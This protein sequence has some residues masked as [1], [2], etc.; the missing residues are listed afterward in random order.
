MP[1]FEVSFHFHKVIKLR[2]EAPSEE[3]IYAVTDAN[4]DFDPEAYSPS[5]VEET[6]AHPEI[7]VNPTTEAAEHRLVDG[8]LERI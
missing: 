2:V 4:D 3:A 7:D 1:V 8:D 5:H 6:W